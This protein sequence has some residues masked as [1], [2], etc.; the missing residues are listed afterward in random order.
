LAT[1]D[2]L[3]DLWQA[4]ARSTTGFQAAALSHLFDGTPSGP[5]R[6]LLDAG[7]GRG[8]ASVALAGQ[9]FEV[10]AIDDSPYALEQAKDNAV[11]A[12]V[13][14]HVKFA[15]GDVTDLKF[16]ADEF[17]RVVCLGV[18]MHVPDV[19]KAVDE[20]CRVTK[21]GGTLYIS[22]S[23][24]RSPEA[25]LFRR[26]AARRSEHREWFKRSPA[27]VERWVERPGG[28][29]VVRD[30]RPAWMKSRL[31]S[32]GM[33]KVERRV[34]EFTEAHRRLPSE[35][36]RSGVHWLNGVWLRRVR[37][38]YLARTNLYVARKR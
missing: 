2:E 14:S 29:A 8:E 21:P 27:G 34:Y 37:L 10:Q 36:L 5:G 15:A 24:M 11:K 38:P 18:L 26:V 23:N 3:H 1:S 7:C 20:L 4:D 19:A 12:G 30:V 6:L 25:A 32:G 28:T 9:G 17:D 33:A 35:R 13:A 16:P 22:E 31:Q